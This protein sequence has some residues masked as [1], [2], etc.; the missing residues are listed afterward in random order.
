MGTEI[1]VG[2]TMETLTCSHEGCGITFAAPQQWVTKR[3][4][5]HETWY[6]PNGHTMWFPGKSEAEKLRDQL[7]RQVAR[8]DQERAE[9]DRQRRLREHAELSARAMKGQ[10]TKIKNRVGNGV[11]PCCNRTFADLQ[12]HME[13][14]HPSYRKAEE[15]KA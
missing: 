7:A 8:T 4:N 15:S 3:R 1:I 12:R 14:K 13:T 2:V 6:C 11:C 9:A 10:V 5:D